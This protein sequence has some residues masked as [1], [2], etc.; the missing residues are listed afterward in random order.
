MKNESQPKETSKIVLYWQVTSD[1]TKLPVFL[2]QF[3]IPG[4]R[5]HTWRLYHTIFTDYYTKYCDGSAV[6]TLFV[7]LSRSPSSTFGGA[8]SRARG[9]GGAPAF[10]GVYT[11]YSSSK[12]HTGIRTYQVPGMIR[13]NSSKRWKRL[14]FVSN[15]LLKLT[16]IRE[17][18]DLLTHQ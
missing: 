1:K 11:S 7:F 16:N 9:G 2:R 13:T 4:S 18:G 12:L 3:D 17:A 15:Y 5:G 14:V 6:P 10:L 8:L